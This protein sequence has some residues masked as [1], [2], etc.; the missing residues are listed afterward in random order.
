MFLP[1]SSV[2]FMVSSAACAASGVVN[3]TKPKPWQAKRA[4]PAHT[5][6]RC[7]CRKSSNTEVGIHPRRD[8]QTPPQTLPAPHGTIKAPPQ[9]HDN[10]TKIAV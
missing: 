3:S 10:T 2:S 1:C 9:Q 4:H 7:C 5:F 6:T 8:D